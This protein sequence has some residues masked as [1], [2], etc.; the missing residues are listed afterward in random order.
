MSDTAACG[1]SINQKDKHG[2]L[3]SWATPVL[4]LSGSTEWV[5]PIL[6][7]W[8]SSF[9]RKAD[10][11]YVGLIPAVSKDWVIA[12]KTGT[13]GGVSACLGKIQIM[14]G[15]EPFLKLHSFRAFIPTC[16]AQLQFDLEKRRKLGRWSAN[17]AMPDHYDRAACASE[18]A[19]RCQILD[20]LAEGWRPAKEF[21]IPTNS[22][23]RAKQIADGD[24][25]SV[26]SETSETSSAYEEVDISKLGE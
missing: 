21:E 26:A 20:S 2:A 5:M 4:G 17:S 24:S 15:R 19:T 7:Y 23:M 6:S 14:L 16:A 8:N 3:M 9:I 12:P 25:D 18:L 22:K 10:G 13:F 11:Q 1:R